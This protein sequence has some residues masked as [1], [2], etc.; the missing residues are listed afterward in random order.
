MTPSGSET[1]LHSFYAGSA[2]SHPIAALVAVSGELYGTTSAG[3]LYNRGVVFKMTTSGTE[4]VLYNF[5]SNT[6]DGS[7][8]LSRLLSIGDMLYGTTYAG[9]TVSLGTVFAVNKS[10]G[11]ETVLHS[12]GIG[13][14]GRRPT[15]GR[16]L[17]VGDKL[18]GTTKDGGGNTAPGYG[19]VYSIAPTPSGTYTVVH[20]FDGGSDGCHPQAGLVL[21]KGLLYGTTDGCGAYGAGT[22]FVIDPTSNTLTTIWAFGTVPAGQHPQSDLKVVNDTIYG[23][24]LRGGTNDKGTVFSLKP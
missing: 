17:N 4:T 6:A 15:Y 1:V 22:I 14:D 24:T 11:Q 23:T 8:P 12:F 10:S 5:G 16:L 18:Y 2:G 19:T 21:H 7:Q 9:G 3:G 20:A 13:H